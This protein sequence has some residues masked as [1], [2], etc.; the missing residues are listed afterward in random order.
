MARL[1]MKNPKRSDNLGP[2]GGGKNKEQRRCWGATKTG[3]R[4]IQNGGRRSTRIQIERLP[5]SSDGENRI[6]QVMRSF[7][8]HVWYT[9]RWME[10]IIYRV[11]LRFDKNRRHDRSISEN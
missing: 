1:R 6:T 9:C 7:H 10:S 11:L 8:L 3:E 4:L 5:K 2:R